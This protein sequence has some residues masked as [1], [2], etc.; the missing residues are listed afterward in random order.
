MCLSVVIYSFDE[1]VGSLK[2]IRGREE[3]MGCV[4]Y[5]VDGLLHLTRHFSWQVKF[6]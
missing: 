5:W 6:N 1:M 3:R 4:A 2:R